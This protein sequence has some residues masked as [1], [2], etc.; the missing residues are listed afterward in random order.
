MLVLL[1]VR[2]VA[3]AVLEVDANV[4]DRLRLQLSGDTLMYRERQPSRRMQ[5]P[6]RVRVFREGRGEQFPILRVVGKRFG[7]RQFDRPGQDERVRGVFPECPS[8]DLAQ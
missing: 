7:P 8:R 3:V 2:P 1:F 6:E 5:L 4:F